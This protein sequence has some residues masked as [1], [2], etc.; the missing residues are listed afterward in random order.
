MADRLH[1]RPRHRRLLEGLLREH[2]PDVEVW[3]YGS[4][5]NGRGHDGSDLDLVLR[6]PGLEEVPLDRLL[7]FEEAVRES[8]I[9]FLVEARDWAR[10][11]ERFH[12][13]I[14]RGYVVVVEGGS[15]SRGGD[16][17]E[18]Q[19]DRDR[20]QEAR[21]G[22]VVRLLSGGT[23][24]RKRGAYWNG[25]IPWV[26]AKDMKQFRLRDTTRHVTAEGLANGTKQVPADTILLLTRGMRLLKELPVC[27]TERP[28]A[29]NQDVKALLPK[30]R[31]APG[32]LPYLI[33]GN[34]RRLLNL[35][36]LAGHGTGRIN[37]D[38]LRALDVRLPPLREQRAIAHILGTLDDKIELNRRMNETLEAK[39]RALFKSWF[40]DFDPVRAKMEGRDTGLPQDIADLFP[41][42]LV[43]SE[44]GEIPEGW[45]VSEIGKEVRVVGGST[46]STKE[47]S[48][49]QQGQH[50]WTTPKDLSTLS[51][52][53]LLQTNRKITDTGLARIGSG[54]LPVG[55]VLLSSRAPIGYLAIAEVPTAVNQ[56]FVAMRCDRHLSNLYVLFWC[57]ENLGY[58]RDIAG[59]STFAEI[60][61]KAFRS[62]PVLVPSEA[63]LGLYERLCRPLYDQIVVRMKN[64]S[65]LAALRDTLLPKLISGEI[66]LDEPASIIAEMPY[67]DL[68]AGIH[69]P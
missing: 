55:T 25:A 68:T 66:R 47:P 40:V 21:L 63:I 57:Y 43:D 6:G 7:D 23:P 46:P 30:V 2:L 28:M 51:S 36:D 8:T 65:T 9:P 29:F 42:R 19:S 38:E 32:F 61:K 37:S 14:E 4:R 33:V 48:Y 22:D 20:W 49:W 27:V 62:I 52:P 17:A 31:M 18:L 44:T 11:P 56:G 41:D 53:V 59:G 60:S 35:V 69:A 3:A 50:H 16:D 13:E 67:R 58:I 39:A 34:R 26:S 5:V 45:E 12:R 24:S 54:L 10:L 1:L 15:P 64:A